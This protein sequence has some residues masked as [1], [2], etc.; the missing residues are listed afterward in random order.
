MKREEIDNKYKWDLT[1]IYSSIEEYNKDF[2]FVKKEIPKLSE[3]KKCFLETVEKFLEFM[4]LYENVSRKISKLCMYSHLA[5]DVEPDNQEIQT[6]E[7]NNEALANEYNNEIVFMEL[8]IGKNEKI[9]KELIK[10]N[11]CRKYEA[12][13]KTILRYD[14]KTF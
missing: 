13:I 12:M 14:L 9:V 3:Y 2:E 7:A 5:V 1:S 11:R 4:N 6:L 8:E 10:D